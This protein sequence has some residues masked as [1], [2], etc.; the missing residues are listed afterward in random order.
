MGKFSKVYRVPSALFSLRYLLYGQ[1]AAICRTGPRSSIC[2]Q[3]NLSLVTG[4]PST[5]QTRCRRP[6]NSLAL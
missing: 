3:T 2:G 5:F 6:T 4:D 1:A